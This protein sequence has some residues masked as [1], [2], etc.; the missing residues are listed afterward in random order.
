MKKYIYL[1]VFTF[2]ALTIAG[3]KSDES[4]SDLEMKVANSVFN[5]YVTLVFEDALTGKMIETAAANPMAVTLS[6][7]DK[8][9]VMND[10]GERK[11]VYQVDGGLLPFTLDPYGRA[12]YP[13]QP[14]RL[15]LTVKGAGWLTVSRQITISETGIHKIHVAMIDSGTLT[16]GVSNQK[17][18][19]FCSLTAG[20]VSSTVTG[21][22]AGT[23]VMLELREGTVLRT[24][25]GTPLE[26]AVSLDLT[27]YDTRTA[28][29]S[30]LFPGG[31]TGEY[32]AADQSIQK[33]FLSPGGW[34][35][36]RIKDSKGNVASQVES[37]TIG[38][39]LPVNPDLYMPDAKRTLQTGDKLKIMSFDE[40]SARWNVE[41]EA[42]YG[43]GPVKIELAHLSTW[44]LTSATQASNLTI[45][46][47]CEEY[48]RMQSFFDF[49]FSEATFDIAIKPV[50]GN[51][52]I[53]NLFNREGIG[54]SLTPLPAGDYIATFS[55]RGTNAQAI[56][57]I[58]E[59]KAFTVTGTGPQEVE[60]IVSM[61]AAFTVLH[62]TLSYKLNTD[63]QDGVGGNVNF[64]FRKP[65][66]ADWRYATTGQVG[67]MSLQMEQGDYEVQINDAGI[68]KPEEG[69]STINV[70]VDRL[71]S[72]SRDGSVPGDFDFLKSSTATGSLP[73]I[74]TPAQKL[75]QVQLMEKVANGWVEEVKSMRAMAK[76]SKDVMMALCVSDHLNFLTSGMKLLTNRSKMIEVAVRDGDDDE[77]DFSY[78]NCII[79]YEK[80][81]MS[82]LE[83]KACTGDNVRYTGHLDD[84]NYDGPGIL[85]PDAIKPDPDQNPSDPKPI[86]PLV[87]ITADGRATI[88]FTRALP[89]APGGWIRH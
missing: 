71:M 29:A 18:E 38:V 31:M 58:P 9:L 26:G 5:T 14:V 79:I 80:M 66:A 17:T 7:A 53:L 69:P 36:I 28:N 76:A 77:A 51:D 68:W 78:R 56:F 34:L 84:I 73:I 2:L 89:V 27:Y 45:R 22:I 74:L 85:D 65:G 46:F 64:R 8:A 4:L 72:F 63:D 83:A 87:I 39:T 6:G 12:P 11:N 21:G 1:M 59:P 23:G 32:G 13:D 20:K 50:F 19:N 88:S 70:P 44:S 25:T 82:T 57:K 41:G 3:C 42:L 35:D 49:N 75:V 52:D 86:D 62:G 40:Q 37:G 81:R 33:G 54:S 48:S 60:V 47:T 67:E 16:S 10:A 30:A 24:G 61:I 15:I 43:S 55:F